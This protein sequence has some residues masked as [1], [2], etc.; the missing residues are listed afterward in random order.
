[1]RRNVRFGH[2]MIGVEAMQKN[3]R[4]LSWVLGAS[5]VGM[6]GYFVGAASAAGIPATETLAYSG[7]IHD[8]Q[9]RPIDDPALP[10][11][12]SLW[13]VPVNRDRVHRLCDVASATIAVTHGR[14]R[15]PLLLP[16]CVDAVRAQSEVYVEIS[17]G[18]LPLP[19]QKIGAVPYAVEAAHALSADR[20]AVAVEAGRATTAGGALAQQVVPSG[21]V[22]AFDLAA[23]P[24][25]WTP[26][27]S[28][29]GRAIIGV[30]SGANGL[31]A[32]ALGATVGEERHTMTVAEMPSHYH[33]LVLNSYSPGA[34]GLW[35]VNWNPGTIAACSDNTA[36]PLLGGGLQNAMT[37]QP[38]GSGTPFNVLPPSLTL[39]YC[40]KT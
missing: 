32:R 3:F 13:D 12:V 31:S 34:C 10:I 17:L 30:N 7:V 9:G 26:M 23:C 35:T 36:P 4:I 2:V 27:A 16:D 33:N 40:R 20:A 6:G 14:F 1:M 28:A 11:G 22:M 24:A 37:I 15:V 25:G 18:G 8:A 29:A 5:C 38:N 21:A 19:R 39:L